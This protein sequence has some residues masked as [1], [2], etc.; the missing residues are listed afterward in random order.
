MNLLLSND[1]GFE[2]EGLKILAR[3]LSKENN[4]YVIAPSGNRSAVSNGITFFGSNQLK[5]IED[6]VWSCSGLP[7]DCVAIGLQGNLLGIKIDAVVAGINI[8]SNLGTDI[9]YSG[10]CACARQAVL[11]GVPGIAVSLDSVDWEKAHKE[12]YKF[13]AIADFVAKNIKNLVASSQT[14]VPRAFVN[15]NGASISEYKGVKYTKNLCIRDYADKI[16]VQPENG[17]LLK[18]TL[19][20]KLGQ[21]PVDPESDLGL[22]HDGYVVVSRVLAEPVC[23]DVVDGIDFSL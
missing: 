19:I 6:N 20:P 7:A 17:E 5:K 22:C 13:D 21:S 14:S 10:T 16:D 9:V 2:S 3:Y 12:G 8:G 4:V 18:S 11:D 23:L 15:V 1:D